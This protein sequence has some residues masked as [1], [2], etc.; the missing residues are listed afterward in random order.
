MAGASAAP[1]R[2]KNGIEAAQDRQRA[3][4]HAGR[5]RAPVAERRHRRQRSPRPAA[6]T[7]S[8]APA[9]APVR[10]ANRRSPRGSRRKMRRARASSFNRIAIPSRPDRRYR[11]PCY[12]IASV[13]LNT[14]CALAE[15]VRLL[16]SDD[17]HDRHPVP[18]SDEARRG[19]RSILRQPG[20]QRMPSPKLTLFVTPRLPAARPVRGADRADRRGAP[21]LDDLRFQW[22]CRVPDQRDVRSRRGR[23][24]SSPRSRRRITAL[25][26]LDPAHGE[27]MQGQRYA[28]GQEFKGHTDYFE[29]NGVDYRRAIARSRATGPGR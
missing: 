6:R 24:R 26:G 7:A 22:R 17:A 28:V 27:P 13:W 29:P 15:N 21:A 11:M 9:T 20:V 14:N 16:A 23:S 3:T 19:R 18:A 2:R 4:R 1:P 8:P 25:T 5:R 10:P 12:T